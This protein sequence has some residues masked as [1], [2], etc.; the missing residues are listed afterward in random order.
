MAFI[1]NAAGDLIEDLGGGVSRRARTFI[2]QIKN[3]NGAPKSIE[4]PVETILMAGGND[5]GHDDAPPPWV[6]RAFADVQTE[7]ISI[8]D[9]VTSQPVTISVAGLAVAIA[10]R[11]VKWFLEDQTKRISP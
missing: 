10:E 4:Y 3:P 2:V 8:T 6:N 11:F 7:T 1:P 9:P 5:I